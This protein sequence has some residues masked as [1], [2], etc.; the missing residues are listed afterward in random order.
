MAVR[1]MRPRRA[2]QSA[3]QVDRRRTRA[4]GAWVPRSLIRN[5]QRFRA[6]TQL[7]ANVT[8][9]ARSYLVTLGQ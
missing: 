9:A 2:V 1:V 4:H 5:V 7:A 3:A 6:G 8:S